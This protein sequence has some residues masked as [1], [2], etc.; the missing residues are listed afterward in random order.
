MPVAPSDRAKKK[1]EKKKKKEIKIRLLIACF[2]QEMSC[3]LQVLIAPTVI[4]Q[5]FRRTQKQTTEKC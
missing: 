5:S 1:K 3:S 4:L 2:E